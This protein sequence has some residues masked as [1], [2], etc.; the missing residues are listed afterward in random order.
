MRGTPPS[1]PSCAAHQTFNRLVLKVIAR[2]EALKIDACISFIVFPS[3]TPNRDILS[4]FA[5]KLGNKMKEMHASIFKASRRAMTLSTSRLKVWWA[6]HDG[7]EGGVPLILLTHY[8]SFRHLFLFSTAIMH[9]RDLSFNDMTSSY[10]AGSLR[11]KRPNTTTRWKNVR[12][13][14][15]AASLVATPMTSMKIKEVIMDVKCCAG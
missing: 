5:V 1:E 4:R 9:F 13:P 12:R 15:N 2:L 7:S 8:I 14:T 10:P 3:F 6:A 11:E